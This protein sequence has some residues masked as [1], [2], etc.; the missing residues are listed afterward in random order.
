MVERR[1]LPP[2]G[3]P[4]DAVPASD[5]L[6]ALRDAAALAQLVRD[7]GNDLAA[8]AC[9]LLPAIDAVLDALAARPGCLAAAMSGSGATCFGLF[10]S[11]EAAALAAGYLRAA[12]PAWWVAASELI[13][14]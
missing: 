12:E 2:R 6:P 4:D 8:P 10:A 9:A 13:G 14:A 3:R 5:A 7:G 11:T 1:G